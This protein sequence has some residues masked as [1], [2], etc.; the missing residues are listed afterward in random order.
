MRCSNNKVTDIPG[1]LR[2]RIAEIGADRESGAAA[3]LDRAISVLRDALAAQAPLIEAARALCLAQPTMAP[4]WNAA[5]EAIAAQRN[6]ERFE[7]FAQ[8]VARAPSALARFGADLLGGEETGAIHLVTISNS[9]SVGTVVEAVHRRRSVRLSCSESRPALEGRALAAACS[10]LG[11]AVTLFGD[12]AIGHAL[13]SADAVLLG[14]DAVAPSWFVNKSGTAMLAAAASA[15]GIPV[16]VVA[17]RDKFVTEDVAARLTL[18]EGP[19][20]E[21]WEAAPA[22]VTVRNPYFE[23]TSL[24]LVTAVISDAGVLGAALVRDVCRSLYDEAMLRALDEM[25]GN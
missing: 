7:H 23:A 5:L 25:G 9:R 16:Y 15:R 2:R 3:L 17:S 21:I 1:E 12:A 24:D 22:S 10:P 20:Q 11:I 18:R 13:A 8:R 6:P 14:A 19:P 4:M